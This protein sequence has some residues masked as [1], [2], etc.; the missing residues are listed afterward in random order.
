MSIDLGLFRPTIA[1]R[2]DDGGRQTAGYRGE[3]GDCVVRAIAIASGR[4]YQ[5][6]Y[7]ALNELVKRERP[8]KGAR[9][10]SSRAGVPKKIFHPYI[11]GLGFR[12]VPCMRIGSGCAVHLQTDELPRG[13]LIVRLSRHLAA[14]IDGVLHD[15]GDCSRGGTRCVYGYYTRGE[16]MP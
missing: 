16:V 4:S 13:R 6:V 2:Y 12:W 1:F 15:L 8:R 10:F 5:E 7:D 3:A 11:L 14:V 9:R